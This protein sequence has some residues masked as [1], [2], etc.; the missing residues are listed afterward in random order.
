[1]IDALD[2]LVCVPTLKR[3]QIAGWYMFKMMLMAGVS[4]R[5]YLRGRDWAERTRVGRDALVRN[6]LLKP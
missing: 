1:M 6:G 2:N 4:P 5:T 3:R